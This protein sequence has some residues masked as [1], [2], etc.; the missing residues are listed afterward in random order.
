VEELIRQIEGQVQYNRSKNLICKEP[1]SDFGFSPTLSFYIRENLCV[2]KNLTD[3]QEEILLTHLVD[4]ALEALCGANQFYYFNTVDR[5]ALRKIYHKLYCEITSLSTHQIEP[6]LQHIAIQHYRTLQGWIK[7]SNPF[8]KSLYSPTMA[9]LEHEVVCGE[10]SAP[11]Q[12]Q[13]LQIDMA[14]LPEP[15][16]DIGCGKHAFLVDHLRAKGLEAYGI[17]RNANDSPF[18]YQADWFEFDL[19]SKSWGSI[20]SNVGFSNHFQHH[21][22]RVNGDYLGYALRYKQILQSLKAGGVF[23]YAPDLPF[24]E[25]HLD[26]DKF[27]IQKA[28]IEGTQ[29]SRTKIVRL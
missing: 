18:I 27:R 3:R 21:H 28:A 16:L 9:Y 1:L 14:N 29:F 25:K 13:L 12:L 17:D 8:V 22:L 26:T 7:R 11:M 19:S 20:I 15:I 6:G 10:Y 23:Y 4:T 5:I 24:I 2:V